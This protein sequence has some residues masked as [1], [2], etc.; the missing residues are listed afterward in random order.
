MESEFFASGGRDCGIQ[1]AALEAKAETLSW[2]SS[3]SLMACPNNW[4]ATM[5]LWSGLSSSRGK[6]GR[7]LHVAAE[8]L[9]Y[10]AVTVRLANFT[11]PCICLRQQRQRRRCRP[12][13]IYG[14]DA[15]TGETAA[16]AVSDDQEGDG[17]IRAPTRGATST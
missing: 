9:N 15:K 4:D 7:A 11:L 3:R 12:H 14:I 16:C 2:T 6:G 1:A 8:P 5:P 10:R 13:Y 17:Y